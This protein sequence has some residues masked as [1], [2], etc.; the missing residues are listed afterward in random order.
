[1]LLLALVPVVAAYANAPAVGF[2]WDDH[3]LIEQNTELHELRAPWDYLTRSFWQHPFLRGE[4]HAFYRPLVTLSFALD[5]QW[6][7]GAPFSFHL[8]NVLLHLVVCALVFLLSRALGSDAFSAAVCTALFGVMPRLT[9]SV[10]WIAGRTDVLATLLVLVAL[11][12][13]RRE[14]RSRATPW[15]VAGL[16]FVALLAKEVALTAGIVVF[17]AALARRRADARFSWRLAHDLAPLGVAVL[18]WVSLRTHA[19]SG[20]TGTR[21]PRADLLFASFGHALHML[22]T[23][24]SPTAQ[25]GSVQDPERWAQVLG[26]V[27]LLGIATVVAVLWRGPRPD[28]AAWVLGAAGGLLMVSLMVATVALTMYPLAADRFLYLPLALTAAV[29]AQWRWPRVALGLGA[30]AVV[31]LGWVTLQR[32]AVWGDELAFWREVVRTAH[33]RNAGAFAGLGDALFEVTRL[34]DA[35]VAYERAEAVR[36]P[37][38]DSPTALALAVVESR[39]G[40]DEAALN[41]LARLLEAAPDWRR[42]AYAEVLFRARALDFSGARAALERNLARWGDDAALRALRAS[43]DRAEPVLTSRADA[44]LARALALHEL[45]ATAK[46]EAIFKSLLQADEGRRAAAQWLVVF[47][48]E[49]LARAALE[50]LRDEPGA[51][52]TFEERFR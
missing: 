15:L 9:E 5:W 23:P 16:L 41:R 45:G 38:A 47:G 37:Q 52:A 12:V 21:F 19:T 30:I 33:P 40:H 18:V 29:A 8:T 26:V 49:P 1:M 11:L 46:A 44:P 28:L 2:V 42:A 20:T 7:G 34:E 35:R 22:M 25:I 14:A 32:N 31:A 10:T 48:S 27:F 36:P 4:G 51:R 50:E 17:G 39:L 43:L 3:V 13:D 6:G 24:W